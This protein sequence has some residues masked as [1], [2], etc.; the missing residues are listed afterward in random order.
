LCYDKARDVVETSHD[1]ILF[2]LFELEVNLVEQ[3]IMELQ[4]SDEEVRH[5]VDRAFNFY[6]LQELAILHAQKGSYENNATAEEEMVHAQETVLFF[7]ISPENTLEMTL[8]CETPRFMCQPDSAL[9]N[10]DDVRIAVEQIR[11]EKEEY[12]PDYLINFIL[13]KE[14]WINYLSRR[15]ANFIT[16]HTQV[17]VDEMEEIEAKK[18][19]FN[20]YDYLTR[21]NDLVAEKNQSEKKLYYQLSKNILVD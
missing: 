1:G 14:Y 20:E 4:I 9:A 18:D 12:G 19:T 21:M 10:H 15:Y 5:E 3:R 8:N 11:R 2:S 13:D 17:F 6:R 16:E 7:Y